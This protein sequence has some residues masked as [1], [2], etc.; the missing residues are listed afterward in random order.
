MFIF[1][2]YINHGFM[3]YSLY[4]LF[5]IALL[6]C[7]ADT[8][9]AGFVMK[10]HAV[11]EHVA[12]AKT[13]TNGSTSTILN[14]E[15]HHSHLFNAIKKLTYP[16]F[17][18]RRRPSEWIGIGAMLSGVLGLF[19][20]GI[21]LLAIL[22]GVLGMGRNCRTKGLAISGFII[23]MLELMLVLIAGASVTFVSLI[24]L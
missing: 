7:A 15:E 20:P 11:T 18:Y 4:L 1:I 23:G 2:R 14:K 22:F 21:Y 8:V 12:A 19:V 5:T 6:F 3:K 17:G 16:L 10:K 13:F 9:Q 24:L